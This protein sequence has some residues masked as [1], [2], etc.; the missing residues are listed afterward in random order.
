ML[1][2]TRQVIGFMSSIN[3]ETLTAIAKVAIA[4]LAL[5]VAIKVMAPL[6]IATP[7]NWVA[8]LAI[9][10]PSLVMAGWMVQQSQVRQSAAKSQ[11]QTRDR[12]QN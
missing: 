11:T 7:P 10:L 4:S 9:V 1:C 5:S 12:S 3:Q 2:L 6:A 8:A